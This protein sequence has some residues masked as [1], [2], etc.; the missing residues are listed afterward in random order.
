[1][2]LLLSADFKNTEVNKETD[3]N[4]V[5]IEVDNKKCDR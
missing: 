5:Q 4:E 3:K 2:I 1:M